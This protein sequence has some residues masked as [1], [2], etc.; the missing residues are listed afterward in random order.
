MSSVLLA[1]NEEIQINAAPKILCT[2]RL[3]LIQLEVPELKCALELKGI[4]AE[5]DMHILSGSPR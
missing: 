1:V 2:G 5:L 3:W 4:V